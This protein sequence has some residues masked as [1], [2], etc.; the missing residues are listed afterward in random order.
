[1]KEDIKELISQKINYIC[2]HCNTS[3]KITLKET[4]KKLFCSGCGKPFIVEF[5]DSTDEDLTAEIKEAIKE[6][7]SQNL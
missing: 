3:T 4:N 7:K 1:M 2:P 6:A 5:L